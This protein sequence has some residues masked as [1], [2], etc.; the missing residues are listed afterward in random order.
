MG[1]RS[2]CLPVSA[3]TSPFRIFKLASEEPKSQPGQ[4]KEDRQ[5]QV[6]D[7]VVERFSEGQDGT[8]N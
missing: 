6:K 2:N 3:S 4:V 5:A 7:W 1:A 8:K